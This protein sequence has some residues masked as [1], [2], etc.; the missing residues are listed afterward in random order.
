MDKVEQEVRQAAFKRIHQLQLAYGDAIPWRE[1]DK[2]FSFNGEQVRLANKAQ[3]IF[4]PKQMSGA[5]LSI[6][7]TVPRT[8]RVNIYND[9]EVEDGFYRYS[10]MDGDPYTGSN[11]YL[12]RALQDRSPIIY[13]IGIAP[14]VYAVEWPCFVENIYPA[15]SGGICDIFVGRQRVSVADSF[16]YKV[17]Y[18]IPDSIEKQYLI[19]ESKARV[20]QAQFRE[21]VI[22][23]YRERCAISGLPVKSLLEAAHIIPDAEGRGEATVNN[24]LSLSRIHHKAYDAN[25]IGITPDFEIR[26]G[27]RLKEISDGPMLEVALQDIDGKRLILPQEEKHYPKR[28]LLEIRFNEYLSEN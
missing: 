8:G 11:A 1:I 23:V 28:E 9:G 7:T 17:S 14:G 27:H 12:W 25:L 18:D 5:A 21:A 2:G 24:G 19:R 22:N 3:G 16:G 26:V 15:Q 6:K 10:L 4:R 20:H 13:L